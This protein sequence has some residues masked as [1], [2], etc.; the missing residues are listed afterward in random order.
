MLYTTL[1][2]LGAGLSSSRRAWERVSLHELRKTFNKQNLTIMKKTIIVLLSLSGVAFAETPKTNVPHIWGGAAAVAEL[3]AAI[4]LTTTDGDLSVSR[5]THIDAAWGNGDVTEKGSVFFSGTYTVGEHGSFTTKAGA[6]VKM[7]SLFDVNAGDITVSFTANMAEN[8]TGRLLTF[9]EASDWSYTINVG[10]D[11][12]LNGI[13]STGYPTPSVKG[14]SSVNL[15]GEHEYVLSWA[16][17]INFENSGVSDANGHVITLFV[18]GQL[19]LETEVF[20]REYKQSWITSYTFGGDGIDGTFSN[21]SFHRG[22]IMV[23]EPTTATLSLLAL[24]G[25][26]ARRRR[27]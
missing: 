13:S 15:V 9:G 1:S 12:L 20:T 23:P 24:A 18:D 14:M 17:P 2:R 22:A 11:G 7:D 19:A 21:V 10:T 6:T 26:A 25:L 16:S 3:G 8:S 4:T 5:E 27:R